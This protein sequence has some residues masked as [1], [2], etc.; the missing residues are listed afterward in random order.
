MDQVSVSATNKPQV[1][2]RKATSGKPDSGKSA[3]QGNGTTVRWSKDKPMFP[4]V[5]SIV[6]VGQVISAPME[7]L[8][9]D[10]KKRYGVWVQTYEPAGDGSV[11]DKHFVLIYGDKNFDVKS[12]S[13]GDIVQVRGRLRSSTWTSK[14][15]K[16][17]W[18]GYVIADFIRVEVPTKRAAQLGA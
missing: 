18:F 7:K 11:V 15:G 2:I 8:N 10:G 17:R 5:N 14:T 16:M 6:V 3:T 12:I 13:P 9:S 4:F 1:Q